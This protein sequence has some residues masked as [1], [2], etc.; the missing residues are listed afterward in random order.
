MPDWPLEPDE[1]ILW[2]GKP[3]PGFHFGVVGFV[4][5]VFGLI[6]VGA[7]WGFLLLL[8]PEADAVFWQI[9]LGATVIA[10]ALTFLF[11]YLDMRARRDTRYLLTDRRAFV[12]QPRQANRVP[13]DSHGWPINLK[14]KIRYRPGDPGTIYFGI[15]PAPHHNGIAAPTAGFDVGFER[16]SEAEAVYHLMTEITRKAGKPR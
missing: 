7:A 12:W 10:I 14:T 15:R 8:G 6:V 5:L 11:P 2:E 9:L 4:A 13:Q 1:E 3:D 16:I